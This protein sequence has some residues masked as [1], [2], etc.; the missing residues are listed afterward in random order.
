VTGFNKKDTTGEDFLTS[1]GDS[2]DRVV[3]GEYFQDGELGNNPIYKQQPETNPVY[4]AY[5]AASTWAWFFLTVKPS[6]APMQSPINYLAASITAEESYPAASGY[7]NNGWLQAAK[8]DV[9]T[10]TDVG[11]CRNMAAAEAAAAAPAATAAPADTEWTDWSTCTCAKPDNN[12]RTRALDGAYISE[13]RICELAEPC[14]GVAG[15]YCYR[16]PSTVCPQLT[17]R[18]RG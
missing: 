17:R 11:C 9:G 16:L 1:T 3:D 6:S 2:T 7:G 8:G 15:M 12:V 4:I 10:N 5:T 18:C 13:S 14:E